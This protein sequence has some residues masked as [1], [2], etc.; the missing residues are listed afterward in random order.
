MASNMPQN[1][2]VESWVLH[3]C[4]YI[5]PVCCSRCLRIWRWLSAL[6]GKNCPLAPRHC[7]PAFCVIILGVRLGL[8][9]LQ[10]VAAFHGAVEDFDN[11]A[12]LCL[13]Q[14]PACA[15]VR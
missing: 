15:D 6:R 3:R 2:S 5:L 4:K 7:D 11:F 1:C 14:G 13:P 8:Y 10:P 12:F 9:P